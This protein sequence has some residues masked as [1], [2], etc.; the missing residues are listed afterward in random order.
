MPEPGEEE[1]NET[2]EEAEFDPNDERPR[3]NAE[4]HI[5]IEDAQKIKRRYARRRNHF[6][7]ESRMISDVLQPKQQNKS[8][9]SVFEKQNVVL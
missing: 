2:E 7:L 1:L 3:F 6:P 8:L 9:S 4:H 5:L